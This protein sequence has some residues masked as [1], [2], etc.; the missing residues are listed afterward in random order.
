MGARS[1]AFE[2]RRALGEEAVDPLGEVP[3]VG[4]AHE[5]LE[6]LIEAVVQPV[7]PVQPAAWV[8]EA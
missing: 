1:P 8:Q 7:H 2:P 3:P 6:L 4:A 5:T